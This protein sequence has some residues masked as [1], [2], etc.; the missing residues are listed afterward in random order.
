MQEELLR[1]RRERARFQVGQQEPE[2]EERAQRM[3]NNAREKFEEYLNN[4][5]QDDLF[6]DEADQYDFW[7]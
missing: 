6:P 4:N 3:A 1:E 7:R 2:M 5:Q